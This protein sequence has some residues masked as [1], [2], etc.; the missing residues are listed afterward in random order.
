[1]RRLLKHGVVAGLAGGAAMA[2]ILYL[3]GEG[4]LGRAIAIEA[5]NGG[6]AG[7]MPFGRGAQQAGGGLAVL[8]YGSAVGAI[9]A[10]VFAAVRPRLK[11]TDSWRASTAL[12]ATALVTLFLVPF[13]K[14]PANPPTVGDPDTIATRTLLYLVAMAW[15]IMATW[16]SW[17]LWRTLVATRWTT[18]GDLSRRAPLTA[19]VYIF[20]VAIGLA[21]LPAT[22]DPV[23]APA[24]LVW[25]FRM[26]SLAGAV[27]LWSVL[28]VV[29]GWLELRSASPSSLLAKSPA[30]GS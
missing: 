4:P 20:L 30:V 23:N 3:L 6:P 1:M 17:R 29:F 7:H 26:A 14:Y 9:F 24:N 22:P 27:T 5:A 12:A 11:M 18:V 13:L 8:F 15:S 10:I 25:Q 16:A 19:L 2:A 28:G 21:I